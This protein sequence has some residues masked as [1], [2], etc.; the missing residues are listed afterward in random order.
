MDVLTE[1]VRDG[2]L[3]E[4]WY[5]CDH[6]LCGESL[7][8]VFDKYERWENAAEGKG[9]RVNLDKTKCIQLLFGKKI[10]VSNADPYGACGERVGCNSIQYTK[11]QWWVYCLCS[12]VPRQLSL[13]S[14]RYVLS[15]EHVL[16]IIVWWRRN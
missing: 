14:C 4:L 16:V 3:I 12:G 7:N 6:V 11:C 10:S 8:E 1:D 13:L 2:S 9:M 5:T 15:V